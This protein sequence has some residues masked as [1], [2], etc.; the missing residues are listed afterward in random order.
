VGREDRDALVKPCAYVVL[1]EGRAPSVE[2]AA[3]LLAFVKGRLSAFKRPRWIEF[4][5]ELP[6]TGTGK[7]QR[8]RLRS[9]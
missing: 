8:Y 4:T 6:K 9:G 2:L 5:A 3:E 1:K 7:I